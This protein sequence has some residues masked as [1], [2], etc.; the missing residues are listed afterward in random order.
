MTVQLIRK[1]LIVQK[2][3]NVLSCIMYKKAENIS[4]AAIFFFPKTFKEA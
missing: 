4:S 2:W 1:L 3:E